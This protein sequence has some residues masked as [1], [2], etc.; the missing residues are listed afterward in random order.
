MDYAKVLDQGSW[1]EAF[2]I[3][4][5]AN[6]DFGWHTAQKDAGPGGNGE[7]QDMSESRTEP[8]GE[9]EHS[10]PSSMPRRSFFAPKRP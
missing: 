9:A 1:E 3:G 10:L 2:A 8:S 4:L 5:L 6:A 7:R